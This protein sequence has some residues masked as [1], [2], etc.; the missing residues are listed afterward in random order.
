MG[1]LISML[2]AV[3]F[4]VSVPVMA[5]DWPMFRNGASNSG[6]SD[7]T[8]LLPLKEQW[9]SSAP[10]V[11]EN[12]AVVSKGVAYMLSRDGT[13]YAFKVSTGDAIPGF[14]VTTAATFSTPA[15]DAVNGK[16]YVLASSTLYAFNLDG[17]SA[18]TASVGAT[19][20][21]YNQSP[22]I[23]D[24][25]VYIK[26]G[27]NLQKYNSSG[28]SQWSSAAAG[29]ST[30]PAIMGDSVYVNSEGGLIEKYAKSTGVEVIAGGF[31]ISTVASQSSITAVDG[32]IFHKADMVYA[33]KA[34][35]GSLIWSAAAGGNSTYYDSPAVANGVVYVYGFSDEKLYAFDENTG[36]TMG[37]FPSVPLSN[38]GGRNWS[39][40]AVAGDKVFVGAAT[41]QKLKVLGAAGSADAGKVLAEHL[42]F[43]N[44]PQGFDLCSPVISDGVVFA[45]LDGGGLYAFF[46]SGTVWTGGAVKINDGDECTESQTVTLALDRGSNDKVDQMII[47]EDPLF[48]GAT[49]E[50][51]ATTKQW[52]LSAGFGIKTVYVQFKDTSGFLSNVFN[53][54]IEYAESCAISESIDLT[55]LTASNKVGTQHTVTA[56]VHDNQS[57]ESG[58][59][60]PIEGIE[61]TFNIISGPHVGLTGTDTTDSNGEATF[62]YT[63]TKAGTDTLEASF[64][65]SDDNTKKS[66]QVTKTWVSGG[67]KAKSIIA[68]PN[69]LKIKAR[70]S[71]DVIII[72]KGE[73]GHPL[74]GETVR[75]IIKDRDKDFVLVSP[76]H[77]VT[78]EKGMARF[79]VTCWKV[80][81][82]ERA[83]VY[84]N[85]KTDC[86]KRSAILQVMLGEMPPP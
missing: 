6:T 26:A 49:F 41:S 67:C 40:P 62:T 16:V 38:G 47:S 20:T 12:G 19:G 35:D 28:V 14:P 17:T 58:K 81:F 65:D 82:N 37:G 9:H 73:G 42:T 74:K 53:D 78:D 84:I 39:S 56:K 29:I 24:G 30:Q 83:N 10:L 66:N 48:T 1:F 51:Y 77:N 70:K 61:V 76:A 8:I 52:T 63:G 23:D 57:T 45:M 46:S 60:K 86:L 55:P 85:F 25:F 50:A 27:N 31:P 5:S 4:T 59:Y 2:I 54:Q 36:A 3:L 44:D 13:L 32:K 79:T 11:E 72:V 15:V 7:E 22:V 18:W 34:S 75:P 71:R 69:L 68:S 43:S 64:V 80:G 33:Y 21:N